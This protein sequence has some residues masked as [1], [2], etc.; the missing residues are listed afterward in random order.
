[1]FLDLDKC[2]VAMKLVYTLEDEV[3]RDP[4]LITLTQA[5]AQVG[6]VY[7]LFGSDEW[8]GNV[9]NGSVPRRHVS[10]TIESMIR[11]GTDPV[12][13]PNGF[14]LVAEDGTTHEL[15]IV[16]TSRKDAALFR[17]GSRVDVLYVLNE[18]DAQA[19]PAIGPKSL[20]VLLE[21]AVSLQPVVR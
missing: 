19:G 12:P 4:S 11:L 20:Q 14:E 18:L 1:M 5:F 2:P 13:Q 17:V 3:A 10:G 8:W 16:V 21:M 6:G 15:S 9:R 7:G